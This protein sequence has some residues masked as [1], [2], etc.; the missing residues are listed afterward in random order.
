MGTGLG[1]SAV[2]YGTRTA[3]KGSKLFIHNIPDTL[4]THE[5]EL[6]RKVKNAK[7]FP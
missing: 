6:R 5:T 7:M 1:A 3:L 2:C 4:R